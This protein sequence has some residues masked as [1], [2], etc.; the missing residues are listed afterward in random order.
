[1]K[2][3]VQMDCDGNMWWDRPCVATRRLSL[4][5][6]RVSPQ[7]TQSKWARG[8]RRGRG[9][10]GQTGRGG[11]RGALNE[12]RVLQTVREDSVVEPGQR[13]ER[14]GVGSR[15]GCSVC[16]ITIAGDTA[17]LNSVWSPGYGK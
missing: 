14:N 11:G 7:G 17:S 10:V 6:R 8:W 15:V 1:M 2:E 5:P 4:F 12:A 3:L 13:L 9:G 16:Q